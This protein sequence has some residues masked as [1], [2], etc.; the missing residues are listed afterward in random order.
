[1]ETELD[2]LNKTAS[3]LRQHLFESDV[4]LKIAKME[5]KATEDSIKDTLLMCSP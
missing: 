1:M 5:R 2:Q 4:E 3:G